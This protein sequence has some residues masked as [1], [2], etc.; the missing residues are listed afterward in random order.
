MGCAMLPA[1]Q[2]VQR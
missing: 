2:R 1:A